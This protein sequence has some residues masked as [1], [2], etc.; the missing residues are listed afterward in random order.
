MTDQ[1]FF[2]IWPI[3]AIAAMVA[4]PPAGYAAPRGD[5]GPGRDQAPI[6][7][8]AAAPSPAGAVACRL[9]APLSVEWKGQWYPAK[10]I[11]PPTFDGLC[12]IHYD[13]YGKEWDEP[14]PA[15]RMAPRP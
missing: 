12:P 3:A 9:G 8:P 10:V 4:L 11:G 7:T 5:D 15:G 13:N 1:F 2:R 6:Q 14:V